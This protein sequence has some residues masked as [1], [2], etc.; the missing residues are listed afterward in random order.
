MQLNTVEGRGWPGGIR[1]QCRSA[2]PL[3]EALLRRLKKHP[4]LAGRLTPRWLDEPDCVGEEEC[5]LK[6]VCLVGRLQL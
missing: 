6:L 5:F 3:I 1:Q 4:D 2:L